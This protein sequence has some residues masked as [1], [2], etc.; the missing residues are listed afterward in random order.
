MKTPRDLRLLNEF[1]A[2]KALRSPYC[3]FDF[4]CADLS[5][6]EGLAFGSHNITVDLIE[7]AWPNFLTAEEFERSYPTDPP[8]KYL[9]RYSCIGLERTNDGAIV[10][11]NEHFMEVVFSWRYPAEQPNFIWI[12][13]IWHPNFKNPYIC[14]EGRPF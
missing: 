2:M 7:R 4:R 6:E 1:K 14:I 8:E 5:D 9:I 12:T 13:P 3:L 11:S 10:K